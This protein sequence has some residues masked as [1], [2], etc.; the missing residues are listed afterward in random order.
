MA[1]SPKPQN[2]GKD[3]RKGLKI[4]RSEGGGLTSPENFG[5]LHRFTFA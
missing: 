5:F 2:A 1:A 4:F 3:N